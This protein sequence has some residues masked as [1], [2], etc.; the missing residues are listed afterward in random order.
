VD[1]RRG[2][3]EK[4]TGGADEQPGNDP[5][6]ITKAFDDPACGPC[7]EEVSAEDATCTKEDWKSVRWNA[8]RRCG[9]RMSLRLTPT[10]HR[11]KRLVTRMS[12]HT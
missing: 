5:P 6:L 3:K 10:A 4:C 9:M 8:P 12:G 2:N 11:K 1:V 7:G